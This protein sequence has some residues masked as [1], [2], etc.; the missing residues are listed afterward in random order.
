MLNTEKENEHLIKVR[1]E[2]VEYF[3]NDKL[4]GEFKIDIDTENWI[5]GFQ[6]CNQQEVVF[7][8]LIVEETE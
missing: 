7:S 1:G 8:N 2:E 5:V 4:V 6:V 3:V